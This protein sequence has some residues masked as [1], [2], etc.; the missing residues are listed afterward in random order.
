M[1]YLVLARKCRPTQF[2]DVIG[3]EYITKTL[4]N[5]ITHDRIAHAYLFSGPRGVGKTTTARLLAKA[6]NC[7]EGPTANP[8]GVCSTCKEIADGT[9][10]EVLEVDGA[11]NNGVDQVRTLTDTI[12]YNS[13][14]GK[15]KV[16]IIDEV[17]ML[18]LPAFNA[19]LK[20]LEE[21]PPKVVFIFATT[22]IH[23]VPETIQSRCQQFVFN[24]IKPD[25]IT[26]KLK[27]IVK[28]DNFKV[29]ENV[30][31][32]I[33]R[34][35]GGSMRDAESIFEK[36]ITFCGSK[37]T[38]ENALQALGLVSREMFFKL[39]RAIL[40]EDTK[41]CF[42]IVASVI[43][44]GKNLYKFISEKIDFFRNML[45]LSLAKDSKQAKAKVD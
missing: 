12:K 28:E 9:S 32:I 30:F 24:L 23:K 15:Y 11:S 8:C 38:E 33:A 44:E 37:I 25:V 5:A 43:N 42:D 29:E 36:I 18:S 31:S 6:L 10:L 34:A 21:P 7:Q 17:H 3:Q 2:A 41:S 13:A 26:T 16:Y 20:S 45:F 14:K 27:K 39:T 19:L 35:S 1:G 40:D 4:Q 22:E